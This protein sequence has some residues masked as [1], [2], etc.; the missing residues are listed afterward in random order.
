[1]KA[2]ARTAA[3]LSLLFL[4]V[5]GSCNWITAQRSDVG[6]WYFEWE[7]RIPFVPAM[8]LPYMSIDLF[9]IA[10][11]FLCR[12]DRERRTLF[13]RITFAILAAGACFLLFPLRFA[14]ERPQASGWL[15][16]LF[17]AFRGLD[18][19]H[20]LFPSLHI[21]LQMILADLYLRRTRGLLHAAVLGWFSLV[22]LSTVLTYQHHVMDI[23]GGFVLAI[24]CFYLFPQVE[25]SLPVVPNRRVGSL[26]G[27]GAV[28]AGVLAAV[29]WPWGSL[30]LWPAFALVLAAAAYLGR[31]PGVYRKAG[32]RLPLA[33]RFVLQPLLLGQR[34]SLLYYRRQCRPWDEAAP[35]V[36]IGSQL[37]DRQAEGAVHQGVTA[38]LDLTAEFSEARPFL[39]M[40]YLNL[41]ILD[42]TAPAPGLLSEAASFIAEHSRRGTVY[43]HCKIGYSRSAAVVGAYLLASGQASTAAEAVERLRRVRPSIVV[44]PEAFEALLAF[45]P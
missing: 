20:N 30:L 36:W 19:P 13:R 45:T 14:F 21:T 35:R 5:Y 37:H 3:L 32:G 28:V 8:I 9:F 31:G 2:S 15:G 41:P 26:Y 33:A 39:R 25:S 27:A 22:V 42:L 18:Q 12:H 38:V 10:A 29:T 1:M 43:V 6:T 16:A 4:V 23:V 17:D 44:R 24:Y 34:L 7:R 40:A 11:P